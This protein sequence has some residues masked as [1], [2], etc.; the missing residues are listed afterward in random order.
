VL[1]RLAQTRRP[2]V[3]PAERLPVLSGGD[4]IL[5][6]Q[7]QLV[8]ALADGD[9]SR[10]HTHDRAYLCTRSLRELEEVLP[11]EQFIRIH[12]GSLANVAR[13]ASVGREGPDRLSVTMDD[14]AATTLPVARR[15]SGELR[16]RLRL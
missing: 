8:F 11:P 9:Y 7:E 5:L 1:A 15:K 14:A 13:I 10:V 3:A 16:R 2:A 4:T 6:D 12:R